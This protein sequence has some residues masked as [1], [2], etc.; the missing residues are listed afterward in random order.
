MVIQAQFKGW[1]G[2]LKTKL[3]QRICLDSSQYHVFNNIIIPSRSGSTQIDHVVV[4]RYGL[5]VIETKDKGGWIYG[6]RDDKKWTQIFPNGKKFTF[7]NPIRQNYAHTKSLAEFLSIDHN[8][9]F[10]IVV[11]WGDCE[12]KTKM[13]ENVLGR[14]FTSYIKS[15]KQ[16]LISDV[17]VES[18]CVNLRNVKNNMSLLAGWRHTKDLKERF[19]NTTKCP[20][21]GGNLMERASRETGKIFIGCKNFPRCRYTKEL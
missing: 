8:N 3:T 13:P 18:I 16:I 17:E 7:Q 6:N 10:S 20:K 14:N 9:I 19:K 1:T 5:F 21:C 15:K 2:E 4:S 11:F 12:F